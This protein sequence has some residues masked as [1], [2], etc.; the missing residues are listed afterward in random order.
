MCFW[1]LFP[2]VFIALFVLNLIQNFIKKNYSE[3][4]KKM[5]K[6]F[7]NLIE[8]IFTILYIRMNY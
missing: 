2:A 8:I 5:H 7:K 1:D 4:I 6:I 3:E